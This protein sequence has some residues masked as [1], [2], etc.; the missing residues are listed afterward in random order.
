[1]SSQLD[2]Q[3]P[4]RGDRRGHADAAVQPAVP[5]AAHTTTREVKQGGEHRDPAPGVVSPADSD[6]PAADRRLVRKL[7]LIVL[8]TML[9]I[10]MLSFLDRINMNA[11]R[12]QNLLPDLDLT[13]KKYS[14]AN[15]V[16]FILLI[17]LGVPS[18]VILCK[19]RPSFYLGGLMLAWGVVNLSMGFVHRADSLV[20]L[21]FF[22]G[23]FAAGSQPA[24]LV[25]IT[26]FYK[27][28]ELQK[29]LTFVFCGDILAAAFNHLLGYA[30]GKGRRGHGG[31]HGWHW[32]FIVEGAFTAGVGLLIAC[33]R[34]IDWP[35]Q[36]WFLSD[37]EKQRL[38]Q[39]LEADSPGLNSVSR[40]TSRTLA[41]ILTDYKIWLGTLVCI[42]MATASHGTAMFMSSILHD[43]GWKS[44]DVQIHTIPVYLVSAVVALC[45]AWLSDRM[46]LRY[47]FVM[48][49]TVV[50]TIGYCMLLDQTWMNREAKYGASFLI[51]VGG[52][53]ALPLSAGWLANNLAGRWKRAIGLAIQ[54]TL[55]HLGPLIAS[56]VYVAYESPSYPS[57]YGAT[58]ALLWMGALAA[59][60]M[61]Y[62]LWE[63]NRRRDYEESEERRRRP[64]GPVRP[65]AV[66]AGTGEKHPTFRYTT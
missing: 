29:R 56:N 63:E 4:E 26:S 52:Y 7:D 11:A 33:A 28:Y 32:V 50:A 39:R 35:E 44:R 31:F 37:N 54:S 66:V 64:P 6:N 55:G 57:G 10:T 1:M 3:P 41:H 2:E 23:A 13:P 58:L 30:I 49:G 18:N 34:P 40:L 60:A 16:C 62:L 65:A 42:G 47:V 19:V 14:V 17:V 21:R 22:F 53:T 45:V 51:N 59:T 15:F 25:L 5:V 9:I 61:A 46:R 27:R 12:K 43:F 48:A 8:P 36:C 24:I 38:A 20:A